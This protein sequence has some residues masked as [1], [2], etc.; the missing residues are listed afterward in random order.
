MVDF[1]SKQ[2]LYAD[3]LGGSAQDMV[4]RVC[5]V[6]EVVSQTLTGRA[7]NFDGWKRGSLGPLA[8]QQPDF[9]NCALFPMMLARCIHHDVK[10]SRRWSSEQLDE[11]RDVIVLELF[12]ERLLSFVA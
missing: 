1:T 11:Y 4:D 5:C 9:F 3:S 10:I 6:M 2:V 7:F 8:P 12:K